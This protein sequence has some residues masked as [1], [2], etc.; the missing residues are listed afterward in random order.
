MGG[1]VPRPQHVAVPPPATVKLQHG[2]VGISGEPAPVPANALDLADR[3]GPR[4][5]I[6]VGGVVVALG[7]VLRFLTTSPLWLDEAMTVNIAS[8][9]V[10]ELGEALRHDG[11]PPLYYMLLHFWMRV[12]GSGDL[13]VRALSG[14]IAVATLPL[15]WRA[16]RRVG[17]SSVGWITVLLLASSP[18]AIRYATEARMYS[19]VQLLV[20][21]GYLAVH[22]AFE[23]P[24][25]GRLA[26]VAVL[27]AL[28]LLT[29]YWSL[30]LLG[31]VAA[32]L[33][34][35][36][37]RGAGKAAWRVMAALAVGGML[38]L[39]WLPSF[40]Y[41]TANTG[42][43]WG[44]PA[45]PFSGAIAMLK[46]FGGAI[47][48]PANAVGTALGLVLITLAFL[49]LFGRRVDKWHIE[50]DLRTVPGIRAEA[51]VGATTIALALIAASLTGGAFAGRYGSVVLP[52][53]LLFAA[54]GTRALGYRRLRWGVVA[55]AVV[56]G[57]LGGVGNAFTARTQA[58]HVADLI[59]AKGRP[60]DVVAYCPDQ[61][62]PAV[63]RLLPS[64][65]AP[66][67]FPEGTRPEIVD[68]VG[69]ARRNRAG[70]PSDFARRAVELAGAEHTVWLVWKEGY[71]TLGTKCRRVEAELAQ[72]RPATRRELAPTRALESHRLTSS[73][74]Q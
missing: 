71:R 16:G 35:L 9:P 27:A 61:L 7:V 47:D 31:A 25:L 44:T 15:A 55:L 11:S 22:R 29:H 30:Y 74:S 45:N 68:W 8:L 21:A 57:L 39:P 73:R 66:L 49:A 12:F 1:K 14:V 17:G 70:S 42:T 2:S 18:F 54:L 38:F 52:L 19:L 33:I 43:P 26:A 64:G 60:G 36:A 72:L 28:L 46:A 13:A 62:G 10:D 41:Q 50:L 58:A 23:R 67:T 51:G 20:F 59:V 6:A 5:A 4:Y 32:L 40:A 53:F 34:V 24:S 48:V 63:D 56:L 69:Y 37:R 3:R 65:F